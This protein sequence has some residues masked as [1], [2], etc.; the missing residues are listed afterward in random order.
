MATRLHRRPD[1]NTGPNLVHR[2]GREARAIRQQIRRKAPV[3]RCSVLLARL[4]LAKILLGRGHSDISDVFE[5]HTSESE[6]FKTR[7]A[8]VHCDGHL[9]RQQHT[10]SDQS[11]HVGLFKYWRSHDQC[12]WPGQWCGSRWHDDPSFPEWNQWFND[13]VGRFGD[14]SVDRCDTSESEY[15]KTSNA[16]VHCDGHLQRQQ[17][18][19]S[20]QSGHVG[21]FKYGRSHDQCCWPGQ[22]CGS[23]WHDDPSFPEWNQWFNDLVGRFGDA[24][25]DRCDTSESEYFK[26]SNAAVHCDG[27]L[28]RQQHT[29]SDQSGHVGLFKYE[30][31]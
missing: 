25:V 27:H 1:P 14:A 13:L 16:A 21:L 31:S 7:G 3:A 29:E 11:G 5:G 19:E 4:R 15:F 26:T 30:R 12:C 18:T 28:Q 8:A 22:W 9:Q 2:V 23:R 17:H 20:D 10:E 6:Y 24:S